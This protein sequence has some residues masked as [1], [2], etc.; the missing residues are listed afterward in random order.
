MRELLLK[1]NQLNWRFI[2]P[3]SIAFGTLHLLSGISN[4]NH[5]YAEGDLKWYYMF[6]IGFFTCYPF[7]ELIVWGLALQRAQDKVKAVLFPALILSVLSVS[8]RLLLYFVRSIPS[9]D[10]AEVLPIVLYFGASFVYPLAMVAFC[11]LLYTRFRNKLLLLVMAGVLA[12]MIS[13]AF[14]YVQYGNGWIIV[15]TLLQLV[16][17]ACI[18][19]A[20]VL[21]IMKWRNIDLPIEE[22]E[23]ARRRKALRASLSEMLDTTEEPAEV[24]PAMRRQ[25]PD[26]SFEKIVKEFNTSANPLKIQDS[27]MSTIFLIIMHLGPALYAF[28]VL[29]GVHLGTVGLHSDFFYLE[30]IGRLLLQLFPFGMIILKLRLAGDMCD[31]RAYA[32]K[33]VAL[34][35]ILVCCFHGFEL[36]QGGRN[37]MGIVNFL[38]DLVII[39]VALSIAYKLYPRY[40]LIFK[41]PHGF[42]ELEVVASAAPVPPNND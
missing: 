1:D 16:L 3:V 24:L 15:S 21:F 42:D 12:G 20:L 8:T 35:S 23:E 39:G 34:L 33:M 41:R 30:T 32:Y 4:F 19:Y 40:H 9:D 11:E 6:S 25:F 31:Y 28:A 22:N 17:S 29:G 27:Q 2:L 18:Q 14:S 5:F 37:S 7:V 38:L 13:S 10:P 26:L 36:A